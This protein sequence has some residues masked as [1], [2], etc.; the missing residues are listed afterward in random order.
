MSVG[1]IKQMKFDFAQ[2]GQEKFLYFDTETTDIKDKELIQLAF[3]TNDSK[4]F[5]MYFKPKIP[6]SFQAM[7]VHNITPE[8]LEDKPFFEEANYKG[9]SLK[10][11]LT[12]LTKEYIWVAHNAV[13][14]VEVLRNLGLEIPQVICTFK[15]ARELLSLDQ[16][17]LYDLD[18][19]SL[20]FLRYYLGLYRNENSKH[21][22]AH[23]ALSDVY[24]LKDLFAYLTKNFDLS[25]EK[26]LN[27]TKGPLII[28]NISHGKYAGKSISEIHEEDPGYL[29]WIVE[30]WDDKPDII[31]NIK[32]VLES[33]ST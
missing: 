15:L 14:D 20:Q 2:P 31:W 29:D 9:Q 18:S 32:R 3:L 28:R 10:E 6:I 26:M 17:D 25:V 4:S 33:K 1:D 19:Y 16:K 24:F 5:N 12:Q 8:M 7:A 27:I 23:D 13:F 21:S 11:Y 22:I 30:N